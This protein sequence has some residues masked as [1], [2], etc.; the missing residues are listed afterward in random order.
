MPKDLFKIDVVDTE[1]RATLTV[2]GDSL[3]IPDHQEFL[4]S[5]G[6]LLNSGCGSL[7]VDLR[8][9]RRVFSIFVGTI[10]DANV[11]AGREG[12][13]LTVVATDGVTRL[14][15]TVVGPEV[16]DIQPAPGGGKG[17]GKSGKTGTTRG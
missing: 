15:R 12:K 11:K 6:R 3:E 13:H 14:F 4:K 8:E 9:L 10:M 5:C 2:V 17:G 16:L 1:D 7:V